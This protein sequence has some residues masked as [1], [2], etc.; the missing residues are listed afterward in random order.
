MKKV[1]VKGALR[2]YMFSLLYVAMIAGINTGYF[3]V[4]AHPDRIF[5]RVKD[6]NDEC[7]HCAWEIGIAAARNSVTIERNYSSMRRKNQYRQEFWDYISS[8]FYV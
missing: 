8:T 5:R 6:W 3:S 1:K 2:T 7:N 4:V